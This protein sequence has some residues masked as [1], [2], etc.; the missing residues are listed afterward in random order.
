MAHASWRSYF[1]EEEISKILRTGIERDSTIKG[2]ATQLGE[3]K[4]KFEGDFVNQL[5][6]GDFRTWLVN[7]NFFKLDRATSLSSLE[8]RVPLV[9][10]E[11]VTYAFSKKGRSKHSV[12]KPKKEL[13]SLAE[14]LFPKEIGAFSKSS[15]QPPLEKWFSG[16]LRSWV[17]DSLLNGDLVH[18]YNFS[19]SEIR[20]TLERFDRKPY[21]EAYR[22]QNLLCLEYWLR[23]N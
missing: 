9:S 15:F 1:S 4:K 10:P 17:E 5:L 16:E 21:L 12:R 3:G 13:V 20:K 2:Y 23:S 6:Y 11:L 22:I 8:G 7:N 18:R 19:E 14:K